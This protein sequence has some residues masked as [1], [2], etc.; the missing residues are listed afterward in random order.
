ML[1]YTDIVKSGVKSR[2]FLQTL[3]C[4]VPIC[5]LEQN[6]IFRENSSISKVFQ[7]SKN[8]YCSVVW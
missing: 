5:E 3:K 1:Q 4:S 8:P 2:Q 6:L 7:Y